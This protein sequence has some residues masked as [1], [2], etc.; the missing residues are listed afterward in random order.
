[1]GIGAI[2]LIIVAL[3]AVIW[4]FA[5]LRRFNHK[6][7]AIFLII[8]ILSTYFGFVVTLKGKDIDYKSIDGL[9]TVAKLYF[10][11]IGSIF[12]NFKSITAHTIKLDWKGDASE[13]NTK[14]VS[15]S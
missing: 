3:I 10:V 5:E 12:K 7:L 11:W 13:I 8:L 9:Q 4:I 15:K 14:N 2:I 1:M 6:F